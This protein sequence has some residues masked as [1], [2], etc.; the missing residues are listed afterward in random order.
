M[1]YS[2]SDKVLATISLIIGV[3]LIPIGFAQLIVGAQYFSQ[4]SLNQEIPTFNVVSGVLTLVVACPSYLCTA[5][6]IL[7][8][9]EGDWYTY[10]SCIA[11]VIVTLFY[12]GWY[13]YGI[14]LA[15]IPYDSTL[16]AYTLQNATRVIVIICCIPIGIV[17]LICICKGYKSGSNS[18][19]TAP[20]SNQNADREQRFGLDLTTP[21]NK[22]PT[23]HWEKKY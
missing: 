14:T 12:F 2:T 8:N 10:G 3:C 11:S 18:N 7:K 19:A 21:W 13:I 23:W 20:A 15:V 4:C 6:C 22:E 1:V 17:I 9:R 16:C 5:H